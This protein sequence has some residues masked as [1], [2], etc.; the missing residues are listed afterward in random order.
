MYSEVVT[1]DVNG[2]LL[3]RPRRDLPRF[4]RDRDLQFWLRDETETETFRDPPRPRRFSRCC[5]RYV[6]PVKL[7][8]LTATNYAVFRSFIKQNTVQYQ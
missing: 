6:Q 3:S 4:P 5:K 2:P 1:R 7:L 8:A